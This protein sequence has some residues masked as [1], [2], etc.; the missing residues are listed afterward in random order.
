MTFASESKILLLPSHAESYGP[1]LETFSSNCRP[2]FE[3][4]RLAT[5]GL[6]VRFDDEDGG[7][8]SQATRPTT[9]REL[10]AM[11]R[12]AVAVGRARPWADRGCWM[13]KAIDRA[14]VLAEAEGAAAAAAAA[15]G[16]DATSRL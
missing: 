4:S 10:Q 3:C 11:R 2:F 7:G 1:G 14:I 5:K 13:E 12:D 9:V 16:A 6:S 15:S 8:V